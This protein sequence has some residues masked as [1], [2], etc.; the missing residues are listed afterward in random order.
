MCVPDE[1]LLS[2]GIDMAPLEKQVVAKLREKAAAY[3][4]CM[5]VAQRLAFH[6][7]GMAN[8]PNPPKLVK[9]YLETVHSE[10]IVKGQTRCLVCQAPL[11]FDDFA[12][13]RRGKAEIET[14]HSDPRVHTADNVGFAH[15]P[16]N[17]AQ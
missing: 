1:E 13:A 17:I 5:A 3:D 7:Y 10:R 4:D 16:C 15:R 12:K 9:D 2:N 8:A 6:V 11:D 14:A